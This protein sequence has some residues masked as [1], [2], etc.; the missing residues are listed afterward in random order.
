MTKQHF[1]AFADDIKRS[2][3]PYPV[4]LSMALLVVRVAKSF[5]GRFD[6]DRFMK[7]CGL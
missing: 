3:E 7:A 6:Q 1:I 4:R 2:E 5:N